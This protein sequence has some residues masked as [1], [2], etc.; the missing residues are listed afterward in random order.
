MCFLRPN[1]VFVFCLDFFLGSIPISFLGTWYSLNILPIM[2]IGLSCR[3]FIM[4]RGNRS[5]VILVR[6][7]VVICSHLLIR[8]TT[9]C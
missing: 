3:V 4:S 8:L 2:H 7:S 5:R 9:S 6:G 1:H